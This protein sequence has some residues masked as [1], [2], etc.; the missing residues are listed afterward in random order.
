TKKP[1]YLRD[2]FLAHSREQEIRCPGVEVAVIV[3]IEDVTRKV[4]SATTPGMSLAEACK[5]RRK[6]IW[7]IEKECGKATDLHGRV[8]ELFEGHRYQLY[9]YKKYTD[10]RL[11]FAPETQIGR[12]FDVCFLRAYENGKPAK[13]MRS[14]RCS[15]DCPAESE[16]VF[17]AGYPE[18]TH[19]QVPTPKLQY[20]HHTD[21]YMCDLC[22]RWHRVLENYRAK[23]KENAS[24]TEVDYFGTM[25]GWRLSWNSVSLLKPGSELMRRKQD[26]ERSL[27]IAVQNNPAFRRKYGGAWKR[28]EEA[29]DLQAQRDR[30][31]FMLE[32]ADGFASQS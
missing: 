13:V 26:A 19:R 10:V 7:L 23:S 32:R 20:V 1:N 14:L 5:A 31:Y 21:L 29:V 2:G 4:R 28:L 16:L 11:V 25:T 15:L 22:N 9:R 30:D 27:R 6:A 8:V 24:R 12:V 17:M 3:G 18:A